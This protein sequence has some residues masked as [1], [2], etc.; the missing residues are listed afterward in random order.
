MDLKIGDPGTV[1]VLSG[2]KGTLSKYNARE[3]TPS[4]SG[5]GDTWI[6]NLA[7]NLEGVVHTSNILVSKAT[8]DHQ[9]LRLKQLK[10]SAQSGHN[11]ASVS[12]F[13]ELFWFC[14]PDRIYL[15]RSRWP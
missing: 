13:C 4:P 11:F 8:I 15:Y 14:L 12:T 1:A 9:G 5:N 3:V 2:L 10:T 7:D 6:V